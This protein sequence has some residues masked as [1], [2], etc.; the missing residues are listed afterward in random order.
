L[1][2]NII[3]KKLVQQQRYTAGFNRFLTSLLLHRLIS[4]FVYIIDWI[5]VPILCNSLPWNG[6]V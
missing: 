3:S 1:S 6:V 4:L 5:R 2:V